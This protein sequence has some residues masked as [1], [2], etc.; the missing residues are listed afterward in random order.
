M[1]IKEQDTEMPC[2]LKIVLQL[3]EKVCKNIT[4]ETIKTKR[5]GIIHNNP[6][7]ALMATDIM[8][9][10]VTT[11]YATGKAMVLYEILKSEGVVPDEFRAEVAQRL[12]SMSDLTE[13]VN[14]D[15]VIILVQSI[16]C[17]FD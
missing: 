1:A 3:L 5:E 10:H 15:P 6:S 7:F 4:D 16:L 12:K 13:E 2:W 11:G 8:D 9:S 14:C 17:L